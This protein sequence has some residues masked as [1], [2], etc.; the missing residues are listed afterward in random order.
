M[1]P[2]HNELPVFSGAIAVTGKSTVGPLDD[3]NCARPVV[4]HDVVDDCDAFANVR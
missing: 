3:K 1:L 2:P 4:M